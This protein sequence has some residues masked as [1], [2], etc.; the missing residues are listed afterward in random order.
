MSSDLGTL[1]GAAVEAGG[2]P[3]QLA[4]ETPRGQP[5]GQWGMVLFVATEATLFACLLA[6]YF[7]IQ[8]VHGGPWPPAGIEKPKLLKPLIMTALLIS[9]SG[10]MIWADW[11]IRRGHNRQVLIAMPI[12]VAL[13]LAFLGMQVGEYVEKLAKFTPQSNAYGSLFYV[14]TGFHGFHVSIGLAMIIYIWVAAA[15]GKFT[16]GRHERVR[17]VSIYWHFVDAVWIFIL[18]SLYLSPRLGS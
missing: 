12:T 1:T 11:A 10:P 18:F 17:M 15:M 5:T 3:K 7:Y 9:S 2:R 8:F 4:V 16:A 6:S 14:I 13:G